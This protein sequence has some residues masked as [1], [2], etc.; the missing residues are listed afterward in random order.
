CT[1]LKGVKVDKIRREQDKALLHLNN[2]SDLLVDE[3][4]FALPHE[5]IQTLFES[6]GLLG[7][8]KEMPS[9]SVATVSVG[10]SGDAIDSSAA[11]GMG[12]VVSRNNDFT[13]TKGLAMH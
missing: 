11:N 1:I 6:S 10:F 4:I 8:L 9:T 13:I 3:V 7:N 2:D 5:K 12:F